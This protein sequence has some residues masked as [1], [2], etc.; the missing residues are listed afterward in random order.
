[1]K[2]EYIY[3]PTAEER[4]RNPNFPERTRIEFN[5]RAEFGIIIWD[6]YD[7][8]AKSTSTVNSSIMLVAHL[9]ERAEKA[10]AE[11]E[12][13]RAAY[14]RLVIKEPTIHPTNA[15]VAT[16]DCSDCYG[17]WAEGEPERHRSWADGHCPAQ[18]PEEK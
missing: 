18:I 16:I 8:E 15:G 11:T 7:G 3:V 1:M 4:V 12:R 5:R 14:R 17:R 6:T 13:V 10:E 2:K 9:L